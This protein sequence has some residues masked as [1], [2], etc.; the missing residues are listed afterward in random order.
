MTQ[1]AAIYHEE[2]WL[3][4]PYGERLARKIF[5]DEIVD[6][7]PRNTKGKWAGH[8]KP[9]LTFRRVRTGGWVS[10]G[11]EGVGHVERRVGKIISASLV[12]RS[13]GS[14]REEVLHSVDAGKDGGW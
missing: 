5:G 7:L 6:A 8:L 10:H 13:F 1:R 14:D 4:K 11:S 9:T 3:G 12:V 2:A